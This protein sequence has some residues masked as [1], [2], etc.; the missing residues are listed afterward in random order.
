V[1]TVYCWQP[2]E[3]F[4]VGGLA[5]TVVTFAAAHAGCS[6]YCFPCLRYRTACSPGFLVRRASALFESIFW[7]WIEFYAWAIHSPSVLASCDRHA[8]DRKHCS[9]SGIRCSRRPSIVNHVVM[10]TAKSCGTLVERCLVL[11]QRFISIYTASLL[12]PLSRYTVNSSSVKNILAVVGLI[13][14]LLQPS[15]RRRWLLIYLL[16]SIPTD[17][18][19]FESFLWHNSVICVVFCHRFVLLI[20]MLGN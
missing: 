11:F 18:R 20:K 5:S 17:C 4:F 1:S 2:C 19:C 14:H 12:P 9:L 10:S 13:S 16:I 15:D 7:F 3:L 8:S 6:C